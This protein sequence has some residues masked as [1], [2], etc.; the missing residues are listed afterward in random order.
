MTTEIAVDTVTISKDRYKQLVA[1]SVWL[2]SLKQAG[3]D[4]W[5]GYGEAYDINEA[6]YK[7]EQE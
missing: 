4:N 1:D 2:S 5:S 3:V 6:Y 7:Q